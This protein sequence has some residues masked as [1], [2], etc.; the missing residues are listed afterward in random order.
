MATELEKN[1]PAIYEKIAQHFDETRGSHWAKV[2]EFI[3]SL[4]SYVLLL[5]IG[6]GNGKYSTVRSDIIYMG[7]DITLPLLH[8]IKYS[9]KTPSLFQSSCLHSLPIR[10]NQCDAIIHVAV[11]HHFASYELRLQILLQFFNYLSPNGRMLITVWAYE[12]ENPKKRDTKWKRMDPLSTD[13]LIPWLD[14][15]TQVTYERYY[16]LFPREE[17]DNLINDVVKVYPNFTTVVSFDHDNWVVEFRPKH[18][19][20]D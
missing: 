17:I 9:I 4:S 7:T 1:V 8:K 5:D 2:K 6:C 11:L 3:L 19:E 15:Y 14:K 13:Y 20:N 12:Q 18:K 16:H 10:P